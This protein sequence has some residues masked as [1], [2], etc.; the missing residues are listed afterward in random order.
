MNT[1]PRFT[2]LLWGLLFT[3]LI[4][5][6]SGRG[7]LATLENDNEIFQ[8][9]LADEVLTISGDAAFIQ[10]TCEAGTVKIN[11]ADPESGVIACASLRGLNVEGGPGANWITLE[12]V[13]AAD[14]SSL[15]SISVRAGDGADR[16]HASP[17]ADDLNGGPGDD[18]F[19]AVGPEDR[20]ITGT[21]QDYFVEA[22]TPSGGAVNSA[23]PVVQLN[24]EIQMPQSTESTGLGASFEAAN[25][26]TNI[27]TFGSVFIP[28]DP[29]AASGPNHVV[30]VFNVSIEW[31]TKAG[32]RQNQQSLFSFFSSQSPTTSTFDPKVIYD[33][34]NGRFV[35][36]TLEKTA[37]N[38]FIYLAVSDDSDPNGIWYFQTIP[39]LVT[40]GMTNYWA[41]YPGFAVDSGAIY[42]T[43]NMFDLPTSTLY[44]GVRLWI[45]DKGAGTGGLYDGSTSTVNIY[46]PYALS[47]FPGFATTTQPAHMFGTAPTNVGSFL[48]SYSG[49]S[50]GGVES[51]QVVRVDNPLTGPTFNRQT[52][53]AGDIDNTAINPIPDA[54]QMGTATLIETNDRRALNA[55]W[56][57]NELWMSATVL[58]PSGVDTGQAT[59]HWFELNTTTL[60]TLT[61]SDQG[62]VGG[63]D[64]ASGTYTFFPSVAVDA[65]GNVGIGF[66]ASAATIYASAYYA[67]RDSGD[68]AGTVDSS[69]LL[70]SGTDV[71]TR[72]FGSGR[73]R[74]GDYSGISLD[75]ADEATFWVYNE[76]AITRGTPTNPGPEDGRW[77]TR[78]GSFTSD[79]LSFDFGD[80]PSSYNLTL[81]ADD[82]ARHLIPPAGGGIYLG[83]QV[84]GESDGQENGAATGDTDEGVL[85]S[86]NW[87]N[88]TNNG[89]VAVTVGGTGSGC[90]NAWIDWDGDNNFTTPGDQV[91]TD[92]A[93]TASTNPT[94][95]FDVPTGTFPGSG[96][97][98][99]FNARF[100][101]FR[102][103]PTTPAGAYIGTTSDGE[104]EDYQW[105]FTPTAVTM[106]EFQAR[107]P[108]RL[109]SWLIGLAAVVA[110][111]GPSLIIWRRRKKLR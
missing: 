55:V 6:P 48:V 66:S 61:L 18:V 85:V 70:A 62:D 42:I 104:V 79:S 86:G 14:F 22:T 12:G 76:Y 16:L 54:P 111:L 95:N 91:I 67:G 24:S 32:V 4:W 26:D 36:V 46:D 5:L 84:D 65:Y 52:V 37:T 13:T 43:N 103:C 10:I 17:F 25:F 106:Q 9:N 27:T 94:I 23:D 40:I 39:S 83:T 90:L 98:L 69:V 2:R 44:G 63:E 8:T 96:P 34:Y 49:L 11:N 38:S 59:A 71:Y 87:T 60:A 41:D 92:T 31:Y 73:N 33:Q 97:D 72:T 56:R 53:S 75:P 80:L 108:F 102:S 93:V 88:G 15:A 82:G 35:V 100:R 74:W 105:S 78:Y 107:S 58:P 28:P 81:W 45:V 89:A 109:D 68:P 20:V 57:N 7:Q 77:G 21:G 3:F 110:L 30:N 47:G 51:V 64:I 1:A 99:A 19:V 50:G 29:I 101:L